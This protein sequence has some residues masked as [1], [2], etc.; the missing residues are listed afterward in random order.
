MAI[1]YCAICNKFLGYLQHKNEISTHQ[2]HRLI[3]IW[4][5]LKEAVRELIK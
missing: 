5:R 2:H 1:I 4:H 3:R